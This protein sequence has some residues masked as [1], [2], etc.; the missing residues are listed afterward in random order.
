MCKFLTEQQVIAKFGKADKTGSSYLVNLQLPYPMR[1]SWDLKTT[2]TKVRV[3][4]LILENYKSLFSDLL[5]HYGYEK[6]VE[7]RIDVFGGIYSYR[8]MRGGTKL[9]RHSWGIAI[10]LDPV[11]NGL[12]ST[13]KTASFAGAEYKAM[14]DIFKKNGF[15]S[16]GV[17]KN[18]DWMHYEIGSSILN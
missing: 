6:L 5:D 1:L 14:L 11:N 13:N 4:K 12:R 10:D 16:L 18:Y 9:S 3:H 8:A 2:V 17:E 7:L 15:M